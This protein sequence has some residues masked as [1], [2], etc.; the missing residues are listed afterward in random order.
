MPYRHPQVSDPPTIGGT[1]QYLRDGRAPVPERRSTSHVMSANRGKDTGP[2]M[3]VRRALVQLGVRGY[4]LHRR[5]LAG[6]PDL[7]FGRQRVAV[8]VHGCFWHRCPRCR[9]P[10]PRSHREWWRAKFR[11]NR[12]RDRAKAKALQDAG[13]QVVTL[14]ECEVRKDPLGAA[15]K[16]RHV[17]QRPGRRPAPSGPVGGEA[18]GDPTTRR[19]S[20]R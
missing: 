5:G 17:L 10:L 3:A 8:F 20:A 18:L 16:L 14:W 11:A 9:L 6:R 7:S 4:R 15:R 13:W 12:S 19:G 2:E 1:G